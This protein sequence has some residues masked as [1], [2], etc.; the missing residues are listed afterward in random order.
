MLVQFEFIYYFT[1]ATITVFEE[2]KNYSVE[3]K[4]HI[5]NEDNFTYDHMNI[6]EIHSKETFKR[7]NELFENHPEKI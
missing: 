6:D 2:L 1:T 4:K 5:E 7:L 3:F